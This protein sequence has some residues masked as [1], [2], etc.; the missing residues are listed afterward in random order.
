VIRERQSMAQDYGRR[1]GQVNL[2]WPATLAGARPA[3]ELAPPRTQIRRGQRL[4][5]GG[6]PH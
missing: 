4:E 2:F 3:T 6:T 1:A 5:D